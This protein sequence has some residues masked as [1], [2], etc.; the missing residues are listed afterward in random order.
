[1]NYS[2]YFEH[3]VAALVD[4]KVNLTVVSVNRAS[5][6]ETI[7][8]SMLFDSGTAALDY[9]DMLDPFVVTMKE[10]FITAKILENDSQK[11]K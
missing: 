4:D 1:M 3:K 5:S 6:I 2:T 10:Q 8:L 11:I 7:V 9:L